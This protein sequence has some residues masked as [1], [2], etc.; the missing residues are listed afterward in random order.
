MDTP[1]SFSLFVLS[2]EAVVY[3][4]TTVTPPGP[5]SAYVFAANLQ[6]L[7][8][9]VLKAWFIQSIIPLVGQPAADILQPWLDTRSGN[10][11]LAAAIDFRGQ[12]S[13][14]PKPG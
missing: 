8:P 5:T 4:S 1:E 7:S 10:D 6:D 12:L 9:T 13:Q 11:F 14:P 3:R 2:G